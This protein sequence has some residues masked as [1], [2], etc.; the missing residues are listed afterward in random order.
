MRDSRSKICE[1]YIIA[2]LVASSICFLRLLDSSLWNCSSFS[3]SVKCLSI[4][5]KRWVR[6][7]LSC[8]YVYNLLSSSIYSPFFFLS[9]YYSYP[10]FRSCSN[11]YALY[12]SESLFFLSISSGYNEAIL[13]SLARSLY[14]RYS[15]EVSSSVFLLTEC[16]YSFNS[17]LFT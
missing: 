11:S 3:V 16:N 14:A 17:S 12:R 8:W 6:L 13:F 9:S 10:T 1:S 4:F 15:S 7:V 2:L 5:S